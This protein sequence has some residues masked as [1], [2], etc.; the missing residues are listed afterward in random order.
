[1]KKF[2]FLIGCVCFFFSCNEKKSSNEIDSTKSIE[3]QVNKDSNDSKESILWEV[4]SSTDKLLKVEESKQSASLSNLKIIAEGYANTKDVFEIKETDPLSQV[5]ALDLNK[6]GFDEFYLITRS[7]GSGSYESVIGFASNNDLSL[8]PVYVP[9]MTEKDFAPDG[10][11]H[12]YMG[13]DSIFV[14]NKQ[15]Y[16]KFPV[17]LEGDPNCCPTGGNTTLS[18]QLMAGEASWIL[19]TVK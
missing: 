17:Y 1:M 8:T 5:F 14:A 10:D 2:A 9:E 7:S 6:D 13:H 11:Y 12:G 18:Y 3:Q 4:K 15:L 19:K 16:R